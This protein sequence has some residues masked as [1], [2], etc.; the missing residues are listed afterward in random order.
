MA[1]PTKK[2]PQKVRMYDGSVVRPVLYN[3]K[4]IG[5]GKYL[6]GEVQGELICDD[7]G[8]PY[9]YREVGQMAYQ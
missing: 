9:Q 2:T 6:A 7:A 4:N 8:V 1:A 3:G 5:H